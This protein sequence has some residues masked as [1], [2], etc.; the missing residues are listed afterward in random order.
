MDGASPFHALAA[1]IYDLAWPCSKK[2]TVLLGAVRAIIDLLI[3]LLIDTV[4]KSRSAS[5][6]GRRAGYSGGGSAP[7]LVL[8]S[9]VRALW[10]YTAQ[11]EDELSF[12]AGE[13]IQIEGE[14]PGEE[15]W[16]RGRIGNRT[17]LIPSNYVVEEGSQQR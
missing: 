10:K 3:F 7:L 14:V 11:Y 16:F 15:L 17:G 9:R 5:A 13:V 1:Y 4:N 8:G 12:E 2:L 6:S